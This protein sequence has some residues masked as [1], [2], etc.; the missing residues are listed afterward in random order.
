MNETHPTQEQA[1][2]QASLE[3]AIEKGKAVCERLK[4]QTAAAARATD[5]TI[6]EYPYYALGA[7]FALGV[8]VGLLSRSGRE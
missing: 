5:Q 4:Q 2:V 6:R 1:Q 3:S 8:I 7:A